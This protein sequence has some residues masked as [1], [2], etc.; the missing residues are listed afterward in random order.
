MTRGCPV[1]PNVVGQVTTAMVASTVREA[2]GDVVDEA[3][4]GDGG[5]LLQAVRAITTTKKAAAFETFLFTAE[6]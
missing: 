3:P 4:W 6:F 2:R 1:M 5:G